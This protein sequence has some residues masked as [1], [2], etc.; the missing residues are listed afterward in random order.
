MITRGT[1]GLVVALVSVVVLAGVVPAVGEATWRPKTGPAIRW[2][3]DRQ[4]SVSFAVKDTRGRMHTHRAAT[5]VPMASTLKVMFMVAYLRQNSVRNRRLRDSDKALLAPM[6]RRSDNDTAT[7]IADQLGPRPLYRLARKA[8]MKDFSYTRPWGLSQ[9]SAR[10]QAR[11]MFNLK[12][13]IP[14]RHWTYARWLLAHV[15]SSQRWGIG[16]IKTPGWKKLFKGGWG[17]G[18]GAVDHQIVLLKKRNGTRAALAVMTTS[19][20]SHH[21]G[22]RTLKGTFAR[23]LRN[24][25]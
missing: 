19:S 3:N 17:S 15:V 20:P 24:L 2:S 7:R 9:S 22:K 10:D 8:K 6:I 21:Y 25:P 12:Q 14:K 11:F 4:G 18:T 16:K 5:K 1:R 13:F 23:L